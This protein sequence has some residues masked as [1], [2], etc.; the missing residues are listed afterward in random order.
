MMKPAVLILIAFSLGCIT[1]KT[2]LPTNRLSVEDI[3][4]V[5]VS[6][7]SVTFEL[8]CTVPEAN[9][10]KYLRTDHAHDG[11]EHA[12]TIQGQRITND[13]CLQILGLLDVSVTI[14]IDS[15]GVHTFKFWGYEGTKDTTVA[16]Q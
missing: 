8:T 6:G 3:K 5:A 15:P 10:W 9:C 4:S 12:V 7:R 14:T 11:A 16:V 13:P 2:D 1:E